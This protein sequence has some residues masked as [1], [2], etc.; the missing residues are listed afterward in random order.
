MIADT[1]K[2]TG[3]LK[4]WRDWSPEHSAQRG[5]PAV[6][7]HW[8]GRPGGSG[9]QPPLH[10]IYMVKVGLNFLCLTNGIPIGR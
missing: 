7:D 10:L 4:P 5:R 9:A 3:I 1:G 6:P 8:T 2:T